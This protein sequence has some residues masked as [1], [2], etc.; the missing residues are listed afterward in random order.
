MLPSEIFRPNCSK[1]AATPSQNS[2]TRKW[3]CVPA[4]L[5]AMPMLASG[6]TAKPQV[7]ITQAVNPAQLT[8]LRGNTHPLA[9]AEF[10]RGAA[11]SDLPMNRMLLVLKRSPD[12]E[13]A[14]Q[15][16]LEQQQDKTSPNYHKWLTPQQFGQQFGVADQDIQAVTS[17]LQSSGFTIGKV[18]NSHMLIEFS[19]NA[20]QVQA[21]F[22][23]TMHEY[24]VNGE[25]HWANASDPQ[26]PT[27]LTPVV[28]GVNTLHNFFKMPASH[29]ST[30]LATAKYVAGSAPQFTS[31]TGKHFLSPADY[32]VLYN[33]NPL[34][35]AAPTA[36]D[37]TG[38]TIGI[39]GRTNINPADIQNFR[40][41]FGLPA[42]NGVAC[43]SPAATNS[44]ATGPLCIVMDGVD[45][46]IVS[47][48]E[49]S[50]AL[51]DAS[52]SG[53]V[54]P[55]ATVDLVVSATTNTEDGTDLSEFYI[56][57]NNLSD[58]MSES[59]SGCELFT[60]SNE[61]GFLDSLA[62]EAAAQGITS[63]V[64]TGDSGSAGCDNPNL[65]TSATNPV[66]V[67][68]VASTPFTVAVGGT[69]FNEGSGTY[70]N[71]T[72]DPNTRESVTGYIPEDVW[73]ESCV[74]GCG[75]NGGGAIW[76]GGGGIS[77][78]FNRPSWQTGVTGIPAGTSRVLP[79]VSLTAAGHDGYL[80]C[81]VD[82]GNLTP[83][84]A[85][86]DGTIHFVVISG[87]SASSPSFA[88]MMALVKQK[89]GIRQ[90]QADY[91][92]YK[93]AQNQQT[94]GTNCNAS[95]QTTI[96]TLPN[97]CVFNDVTIG[98]NDVPGETGY[99][100]PCPNP[101]T[102]IGTDYCAGTGF[103]LA[104]GLGSVNA[105]NLANA[106]V[107]LTLKPTAVTFT[108]NGNSTTAGPFTHGTGVTAAVTVSAVS[109]A[110]GMPTGDV[111]LVAD[112]SVADSGVASDTLINGAI[113]FAPDDL[114]GGTAYHIHAHYAGDGVFAPSDSS[115]ITLTVIPEASA[116]FASVWTLDANGDPTIQ[117]QSSS[118]PYGS[119][120]VL[121]ADVFPVSQIQTDTAPGGTVSFTDNG[122]PLVI[123]GSPF[124][125]NSF[126]AAFPSA[127]DVLLQTPV[128]T[129]SV[130]MH[131]IVGVYGGSP[132]YNAS[133][134]PNETAA[135]FTITK[136]STSTTVASSPASA[137]QG[138]PIT[139]TATVSSAG[140]GS[141]P[142]GTLQFTQNGQNLGSAV[143]VS[144]GQA[145]FTTSALAVGSDTIGANYSG[146]ANYL[147]S[148]GSVVVMV[149]GTGP[150]F[151]ITTSTGSVSVTSP[152]AVSP[153]V[154]LT[155]TG[156][157]GYNGT[158]NFSGSSCAI[159]PA[160]SLSTCN[161]SAPSVTGSGMVSVTVATTAPSSVVPLFHPGGAVR[162]WIISLGAVMLSCV[163]LLALSRKQPRLKPVLGLLGFSV[164]AL[165]LGCSS[166]SNVRT[167]Q[168]GT[169]TNTPFTVTVTATA[170]TG[171]SHTANFTFTVQ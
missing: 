40:N 52:W 162:L 16:L 77:T 54:A 141:S 92:L 56:V 61:L 166:P 2:V 85:Q 118:L 165:C 68:A 58:V 29:I 122:T 113:T 24:V 107:N 167:P 133:V 154:T 134:L 84:V 98:S 41:L 36:I 62:E 160:G 48:G 143:A 102:S 156:T 37:G 145:Q 5:L 170:S 22:H 83:C 101:S 30:E 80:L 157:P 131:S 88:G 130:G 94:A 96:L 117:I 55:G 100:A 69:M 153:G 46:G 65:E 121:R 17:W 137:P 79:D 47:S 50:E 19:G 89:T 35:Q 119:P 51:L 11:P 18:A 163:L 73:N 81:Q 10:D 87:T 72:N 42:S 1:T 28:A 15:A 135:T 152:G 59:F 75:Q 149:T 132:S 104:T 23:T 3:L 171:Q 93:L 14:L 115:P 86:P 70:W 74:S 136:S 64:S 33:I 99:S 164:L 13:A 151:T 31:T 138:S 127:S 53:A 129:F 109:P 123:T 71:T 120:V 116:T 147:S 90:G 140:L 8:V 12:Q 49:E 125:L 67:N 63:M 25:E 26:I 103:D 43:P 124:P 9:R 21:A 150:D 78:V 95:S 161:F 57:D 142:T 114:P 106:W 6:Q 66:S 110:T 4:L 97:T 7:R 155:V 60:G 76:A 108:L 128:Y 159:T 45:P 39:I 111:S 148:S 169:P 144:G 32:A 38:T 34:Y 44:P 126:S 112:P 139:I 105:A 91:I 146:D 20:A 27:A 168:G 82:F 158:I